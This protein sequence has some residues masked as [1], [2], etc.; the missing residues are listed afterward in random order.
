[1]KLSIF[2]ECKEKIEK[3]RENFV[4]IEGLEECL[5]LHLRVD[6]FE[7][8]KRKV[9]IRREDFKSMIANTLMKRYNQL[10]D[11]NLVI[12]NCQKQAETVAIDIE[13]SKRELD[14]FVKQFD[15]LEINEKKFE[16]I[17]KV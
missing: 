4:E 5:D 12:L 17:K 9:E 3:A 11:Q 15:A 7:D 14:E 8:I 16:N 13:K 1:M 10:R 2:D 6:N